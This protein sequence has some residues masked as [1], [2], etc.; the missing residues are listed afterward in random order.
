MSWNCSEFSNINP[1]HWIQCSMC[2]EKVLK[3]RS[4]SLLLWFITQFVFTVLSFLGATVPMLATTY[5]FASASFSLDDVR[6]DTFCNL[7]DKLITVSWVIWKDQ[8]TS[9]V[10][11]MTQGTKSCYGILIC[12]TAV[13]C[14][15]LSYVPCRLCNYSFTSTYWQVSLCP[16]AT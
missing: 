4:Y 13:I 6:R 15:L 11:W 5:M 9:I 10:V 7:Q 3:Q 8:V 14:I 16:A 12:V 2:Y 1:K